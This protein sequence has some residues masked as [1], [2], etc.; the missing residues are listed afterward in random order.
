MNL[1][2]NCMGVI[3]SFAY[4]FGL[5]LIAPQ[6]PFKTEEA[7]RKFVHILLGNWWFIVIIFFDNAFFA[8]VVPF[9][10]I[11]INYVSVKRNDS[12]GLVAGLERQYK[13][14]GL[15]L[16]PI[17]MWLLVLISYCFFKDVRWGGMG[18]LAL[19]YGDGIAA[20]AGQH[21][22]FGPMNIFGSRKS[23]AGSMAMFITTFILISAYMY[24]VGLCTFMP[25]NILCSFIAA[26][27]GTL[28]EMCTPLGIDD[29]TVPLFTTFVCA[30]FLTI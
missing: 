28:A 11:F 17:S 16:F 27:V 30:L 14:Y 29:F 2:L 12:N 18:L 13:S 22:K 7:R 8:S 3:V 5:L 21:F 23:I 1:I 10:F 20:L 24:I 9:S 25:Q 19:A 6:I 4:F 26:L 15:I